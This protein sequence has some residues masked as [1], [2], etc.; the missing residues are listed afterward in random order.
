VVVALPLIRA[1]YLSVTDYRLLNLQPTK[2]VGLANFAR[3]LSDS[4]FLHSVWISAI[5]VSLTITVSL[6]VGLAMAILLDNLPRR[7]RW[8]RAIL[9][10]P[11]V[12]PTVVVAFLF[13]YLFD[14]Q[15]SVVNFIL[16]SSGV[17]SSNV[18]WLDSGGLAMGVA[19]LASVW[20]QAPIFMLFIAAALTGIP[21]D[22]RDAARVDGAYAW[23]SFRY[24]TIPLVRGVILI[25]VIILTIADINGFPL[26]WAMTQGGPVDSTTT[27][28]I[29]IYRSAFENFQLAYASAVGVILMIV[30]L[31]V[32]IPYVRSVGRAA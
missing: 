29:D 22:I 13:L 23:T 31:V 7:L 10:T 18:G 20:T 16:R 5:Y 14:I 4:A 8:I 2:F 3:A 26:I 6:L 25:V 30:T 24:I 27:T 9:L 21:R 12:M 32:A 1:V 28:V 17:I 11:W 19:V 15:V